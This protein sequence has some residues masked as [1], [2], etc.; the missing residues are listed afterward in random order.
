MHATHFASPCETNRS[1]LSG[2][3][4]AL[5]DLALPQGSPNRPILP[6]PRPSRSHNLTK[7]SL[8]LR[9]GLPIL[10]LP[11][12]R[13]HSRTFRSHRPSILRPMYVSHV[14]MMRQWCFHFDLKSH[15]S[16][17][18]GLLFKT[19]SIKLQVKIMLV[20]DQPMSFS[21]VLKWKLFYHS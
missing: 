12:C 19:N 15:H 1:Y 6:H 8:H 7:S 14:Y 9:G 16:N 21:V 10:R 18:N 3:R 11:V 4:R 2:G 20:S 5:L 17:F 13:P